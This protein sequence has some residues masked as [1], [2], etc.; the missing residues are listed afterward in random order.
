MPVDLEF[1]N[2]SYKPALLALSA[3]DVVATVKD[4]LREMSFRVLVAMSAEDFAT[5]FSN[6]Q[7]Q[8]VLIEEQFA[9][10]TLEENASLR[11][12][13]HMPMA[14]RRQA[15]VILLGHQFETLNPRQAFAQSVHAVVNWADLGSLSQIIQQVVADNNL[16]LNTFREAQLRA[17]S[18]KA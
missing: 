18:G 11:L 4:V 7:F 14:Q 8:L 3:E 1:L 2:P 16:F 17:S 13:Q 15:T 9:S 5:R 10:A 12:L 6:I